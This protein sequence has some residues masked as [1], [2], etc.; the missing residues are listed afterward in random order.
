LLN[1]KWRILRLEDTDHDGTFDQVV[2]F[3]DKLPFLQGVLWYQGSV[4]TGGTP[5]I[6]KLTDTDG[7]GVADQR[8]EWWNV[9]RKPTHCGNE[10]HGPY[11]GPDGYLYWT[12][13]AFEPITWTNSLTGVVEHDRAAHIFRAKP[14]GS[15]MES[16]MTG[17]MDNPVE[18]AFTPDGECLFTTTFVDFTQPAFRDGLCHA[19][20]GGVFGKVNGV[21]D[22]RAVKRTDHLLQPMS[23][24]GAAA[25]S[26]LCR[27][28]SDAMG[29]GFR[30]N[31]FASLFNLHKITRHVLHPVGGTYHSETTDFVASDN[32]DFHPTDVLTAPDGSLLIL[33]TGGWY[34]LCCPSS[35]LAKA[36]VLGAIY[37]VSRDGMKV[38][39]SP[40][41]PEHLPAWKL[42]ALRREKGVKP[43]DLEALLHK[44][45]RSGSDDAQM[46]LAAEALG[47]AAEQGATKLLVE[48]AATAAS[49]AMEATAIR[50][51]IDIGDATGLRAA[52]SAGSWAERRAALLALD[53]I[54][55]ES[56]AAAEAAPYLMNDR[57]ELRDAA[58]WVTGR[59]GDWGQPLAGFLQ[60]RL[61]EKSSS[62]AQRMAVFKTM[63][64][65]TS[66]SE[67][68]RLIADIISDPASSAADKTAAL[69]LISSSGLDEAPSAW[70]TA[71]EALLKSDSVTSGAPENTGLHSAAVAAGRQLLKDD[72]KS[73]PLSAALLAI[74]RSSAQSPTT[75]ISAYAALPAGWE[76]APDDLSVLGK[77]LGTPQG[78]EA[79]DGLSRAAAGP[80]ELGTMAT[81]IGTASQLEL[82]R[83]L[84]A[85]S[86]N[87]DEAQGT[88]LMTA[89][90]NAKAKAAVQ[91]D[92]L[93]KLLAKYPPA[94]QAQGEK[95][96]AEIQLGGA[97]KRAR[98]ESIAK[99]LP[100][101]DIRRG[102][103]VFN[104]PKANCIA[105]HQIGY[106][107]GEVG[108]GLTAIGGARS[109]GD[110][111][112]SIVY[113]SA[114]FVR[115][116]EPV[117]VETK[118]GD[119]IMGIPKRDDDQG[120]LLVTGPNL[121]QQI[122]RADIVSTK[123]GEISLMPAGF[124]DLLTRQELSD[125]VAFLKN[126]KWGAN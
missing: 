100:P 69:K 34:K 101:G 85:F 27:Y 90:R 97:E 118:G 50:A 26:G 107:G 64:Y 43:S 22:D 53:Q 121:T 72:R 123:P 14:D 29:A 124:E 13:G 33:D 49:P 93:R 4:Y 76:L 48:L 122:A 52:L 60:G 89:L 78:V 126:T 61:A 108:P 20:Y 16:V 80:T 65:L 36:D 70:R 115:S 73:T 47:R 5:S 81:Y 17:G 116:Y 94:V 30:D 67:I 45:G 119:T 113:P 87:G 106:Q 39:P 95:W 7:D 23:E 83:M 112:E 96:L 28:D 1:P 103:Q 37:R 6:T 11:A 68:R 24:F 25:P 3:A 46:R 9:G 2:V 58:V 71:V 92:S 79:A 114:S 77:A 125:L 12:K 74:A 56:L 15:G 120:V 111:L 105:C 55:G 42:A 44:K 32:L 110:L 104:S 88:A 54:K 21:L 82:P 117:V 35:Q 18:V 99:S 84:N 57:A 102:Q 31:F 38:T 98:L 41:Q 59:H 109:E 66:T 19:V 86:T 40:A 62:E 51:L 10:V 8:V 63:G 75:R 91:P